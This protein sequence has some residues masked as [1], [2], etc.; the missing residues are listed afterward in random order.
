MPKKLST[1]HVPHETHAQIK[2]LR[3]SAIAANPKATL[4]GV[5]TQLLDER[6]Q[7]AA[8]KKAEAVVQESKIG[9]N[10]ADGFLAKPR[11]WFRPNE[12]EGDG[13]AQLRDHEYAGKDL[14]NTA[15]EVSGASL[16][17]FVR[18]AALQLAKQ[19]LLEHYRAKAGSPNAAG[20]ANQKLASAY[21]ALFSAGIPVTPSRL[22]DRAGTNNIA[23]ERW[24]LLFHPECL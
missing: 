18:F 23:A 1:V 17:N 19:T 5:V 9:L 22:R 6:T 24:L 10:L 20:L 13:M 21:Q 11:R 7:N 14:I 16:E 8:A 12:A 3:D 4:G 15:A 2:K